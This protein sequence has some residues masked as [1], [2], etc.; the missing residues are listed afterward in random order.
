[1]TKQFTISKDIVMRAFHLTKA[2]KGAA[3]ID[4]QSLDNFERDLK[5]NL[6]KL[7]NRMSSGSYFPPPVK[8][9][10]IPKKNGGER[11][12]GIPTV[13]DR[14]AQMVVKLLWEPSIE[15]HF[16]PDS[17]G[18]RPGKSAHDALLVTRQRCWQYGWVVEYDIQGLF[19]N[20][21]HD[22]L[23]KA[24]DKHTDCRWIRLYIQRW[25]KTPMQD[26][27]GTLQ[28]KTKGVMQG[29]VISP[30]LSN[31]FLHYV[32]DI[33]ITRKY[34][35]IKWCRY[36]DD[37]IVHCRTR[38]QA[39][40]VLKALNR[41]FE[42]CDLKL[43][44]DKT[45]IVYC[46][47]YRLKIDHPDKQFDF[48]GYTF[49]NR[50]VKRKSDNK[51]FLSFTPGVS[52]SSIRAMK[53][54]IRT[55]RYG[56]RNELSIEEIAEQFNPVIKGW[57][58]YYGKFNRSSLYPLFRYFNSTLVRW[59][60][61]KFAKLVTRTR[62]ASYIETTAKWKPNLFAHWKIGMIGSIVA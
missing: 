55:R 24:V 27:D 57:I 59:A 56:R 5:D 40:E 60:R 10:A 20:I 41:R 53:E 49:R 62:A 4:Q 22:L 47:D 6:Y 51:L 46:Q 2:N 37:G 58:N 1:M 43:N 11:I 12:L 28:P 30:V 9:V 29:G 54:K 3:G 52:K 13:S 31:L 32:F 44:I 25:L 21:D 61:N 45:K 14:I 36:A 38:L 8:T 33:W 26:S 18:Y 48:L 23:L 16:L 35:N 17:Y 39:Q 19:D 42:E 34:P 7:W 15:K 50:W